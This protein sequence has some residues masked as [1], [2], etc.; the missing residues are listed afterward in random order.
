MGADPRRA[1]AERALVVDEV[2]GPGLVVSGR[3]HPI[4]PELRLHA[5]DFN[6]EGAGM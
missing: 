3:R 5:A 2:H 6:E 1:E 4:L